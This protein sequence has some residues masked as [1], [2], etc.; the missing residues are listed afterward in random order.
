MNNRGTDI[1]YTPAGLCWKPLKLIPIEQL[2]S[3]DIFPK[4]MY[5]Q[6]LS[7]ADVKQ[8]LWREQDLKE[9]VQTKAK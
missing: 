3:A 9:K 1:V 8:T 2:L 4:I 5:L 7:I 6:S